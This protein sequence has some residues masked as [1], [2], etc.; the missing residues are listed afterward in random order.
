MKHVAVLSLAVAAWLVD[1]KRRSST[2]SKRGNGEPP[3]TA[4]RSGPAVNQRTH[5]GSTGVPAAPPVPPPL[6]AAPSPSPAPSKSVVGAVLQW[7]FL[8]LLG[9]ALS[10]TA[11]KGSWDVFAVLVAAAVLQLGGQLIRWLGG[12]GGGSGSRRVRA[13]RGSAVA[14]SR[15]VGGGAAV[16]APDVPPR[17]LVPDLRLGGAWIKDP[18]RS[19]SMDEATSY[20]RLNGIVRTAV[21]LIRGLEID[22]TALQAGRF[23]MAITSVIAFFKVRESYQLDGAVGHFN[24]RDLRRG[25]HT[26]SVAVQPD[27]SVVLSV[28][29]GE[30]LAGNGTDR[31]VLIPEAATAAPAEPSMAAGGAA[32]SDRTAGQLAPAD[33]D[34]LVVTSTL[35]LAEAGPAAR[36][37]VYRTTYVRAGRG[38]RQQQQNQNQG[39]EQSNLEQE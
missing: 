15:R 35:K 20:I 26:A 9:A 30:P 12:G 28:S 19:D 18:S 10:L 2:H 11:A 8:I 7:I 32:L 38:R 21:R 29:W 16:G 4:S 14:A 37:V 3:P 13:P 5:G 6:A 1:R 34:L 31:F 22:P 24:R 27:G 23:D 39:Q 36:P 25:K 17:V 33:G